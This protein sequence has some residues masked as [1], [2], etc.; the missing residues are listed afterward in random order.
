MSKARK[1]DLPNG[2]TKNTNSYTAHYGGKKIKRCK[3][4]EEAI[5][6]HDE[7]KVL[8]IIEIANE[9]K[10]KIPDRLY[11]ALINWDQQIENQKSA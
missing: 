11:K 8:H 7:A 5:K 2:I 10:E 4:L 6:I 9:Y 3:T 1:D